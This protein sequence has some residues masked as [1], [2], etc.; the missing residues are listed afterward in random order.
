MLPLRPSQSRGG[1]PREGRGRPPPGPTASPP[2]RAGL[3]AAWV[4]GPQTPPRPTPPRRTPPPG[5]PTPRSA[6]RGPGAR[7][8]L[9]RPR[10]RVA[11]PAG[12]PPPPRSPAAS[13]RLRPPP[14]S[15]RAA[16]V[17]A[18]AAG[19][20]RLCGRGRRR[21]RR[22]PPLAE[23]GGEAGGAPQPG[24]PFRRGSPRAL[25]R[26]P[27]EF[28]TR[29]DAACAPASAREGAARRPETGGRTE[30]LVKRSRFLTV[31]HV[32]GRARC[33]PTPGKHFLANSFQ[34]FLLWILPLPL[35]E[36]AFLEGSKIC[37]L[38][39]SCRDEG[40]LGTKLSHSGLKS[41]EGFRGGVCIY[42]PLSAGNRETKP[43]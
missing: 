2:P 19:G 34:L 36:C 18:P 31:V 42:Q 38:M 25:P 5:R 1:Q 24:P 26:P 20:T 16:R 11:S 35:Q 3:A 6:G 28:E 41:L 4:R 37:R 10:G 30:N 14:E 39:P 29:K 33:C 8:G 13:A 17:S 21:G 22:R 12:L 15:V 7:L 40:S 27:R 43:T 9:A 23:A 32:S